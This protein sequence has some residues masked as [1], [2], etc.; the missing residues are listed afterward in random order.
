MA[1]VY[2]FKVS[3]IGLEDAIWRDIEITSVSSVAK[4]GY[5]VLAAFESNATH[6]FNI[7]FNNKHYEIVDYYDDDLFEEP[8]IDPIKTKLSSLKINVGDMLDMEYDYGAGWRFKIELLSITE[9]MRGRGPHYPYITDGRG[10]GI[11]EDISPFELADIIKRTDEE[12]VMPQIPKEYSDG[13]IYW[14]YRNFNL[15]Y[16]NGFYKHIIRSV[17]KSFEDNEEDWD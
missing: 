8:V 7:R 15:E 17:Q 14:D 10:K 3:L 5:A 6:M 12:G 4:L 2:K 9:M 16:A 13:V 1:D 11:F